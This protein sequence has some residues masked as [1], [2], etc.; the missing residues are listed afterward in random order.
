VNVGSILVG[1]K[2]FVKDIVKFYPAGRSIGYTLTQQ[3]TGCQG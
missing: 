1:L 2:V 3:V